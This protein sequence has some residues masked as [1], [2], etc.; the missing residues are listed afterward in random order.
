MSEAKPLFHI[1]LP[2]GIHLAEA[3]F[4]LVVDVGDD[5]QNL[6]VEILDEGGGAFLRLA[7]DGVSLDPE[8]LEELTKTMLAV[9]KFVDKEKGK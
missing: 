8:E 6:T 3:K 5:I 4:D 2:K 9:C 1:E 7:T